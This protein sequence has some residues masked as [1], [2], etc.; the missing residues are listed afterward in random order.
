MIRQEGDSA[1]V[2]AVRGVGV[3]W[4]VSERWEPLGAVWR[5]IVG[6][7]SDAAG[8]RAAIPFRVAK[9]MRNPFPSIRL[10]AWGEVVAILK[11]AVVFDFE[12]PNPN[13]QP[14]PRPRKPFYDGKSKSR[15]RKTGQ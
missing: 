11:R 7:K 3:D 14:Q 10:G 2:A 13:P 12:D 6:A 4:G 1:G 15:N 8:I 9:V 5:A